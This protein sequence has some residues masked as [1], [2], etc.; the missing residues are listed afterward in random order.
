MFPLSSPRPP[1]FRCHGTQSKESDER[2]QLPKGSEIPGLEGHQLPPGIFAHAPEPDEGDVIEGVTI[3]KEKVE[4]AIDMMP[5]AADG[6]GRFRRAA[7]GGGA[8]RLPTR[9]G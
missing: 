5:G 8:G 3:V 9:T 6:F 1:R 7:K 2:P 4:V